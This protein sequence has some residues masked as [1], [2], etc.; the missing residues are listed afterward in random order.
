[1]KFSVSQSS[2]AKALLVVAK[3]MA[4]NATMP[5]L[6]GVHI[7]A[8]GG[9]LEF[10]TTDL[11]IS[12]RHRIA[13]DVEEPGQTVVSGKLF[14]NIV[15]NLPDA[16][17]QF[18]TDA[19][20]RILELSCQKSR[21]RLNTLDARDFP[22]F[23]EFA[24]DRTIEL[25]SELLADMVDMVYKV[26]SRDTSRPILQGV[27]LNV[28]SNVIR[29]VAS[30]SYRLAVCDSNVETSSATEPFVAVVFGTTFHD[31]LASPAMT[32]RITVGT[33]DNQVVFSFGNTT[34]VTRRLEGN[35]PNFNQLLPKSCTTTVDLDVAEFAGALKRVSVIAQSNPSVRFDVDADG[36]L[37]CLSATSPDQG[38]SSEMLDA[39]IEGPSMPIRLNF[40][41]IFDCVNALSGAENLTLELQSSALPAVFKSYGPINYL[42]LLMPVRI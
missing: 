28:H 1:M 39:D 23:P 6:A 27:Q 12:I 26:T 42:Y 37:I 21:Y 11:T 36:K 19:T 17:I 32:E 33:T 3:G 14:S 41:Y 4:T 38:E 9:E 16:A 7:K 8:E 31:V 22:E 30:D 2:L 13:A 18:E 15:K 20:G 35:F 29:L 5:Y 34:Y 40:H 10:Q 24:L 25:P